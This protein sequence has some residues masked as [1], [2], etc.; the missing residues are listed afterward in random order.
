MIATR[1]NAIAQSIST[2][3]RN[4]LHAGCQNGP[5]TGKIVKIMIYTC[6]EM[7]RDCR[8]GRSEGWEYFLS[9]YVPVIRRLLVHYSP[10]QPGLL[11]RILPALRRPELSLF[12]ALEPMPERVFVA[13]LRQ[14][15]LEEIG[16]PAAATSLEL[17][18]VAAALAPLTLVEKQA[19]WM[20]TMLYSPEET[21][22][23]LRMAPATVA[24]I[25]TR[26][27]DLLRGTV[28]SWSSG[29][30]AA[31]GR[32]L[33]RSAAAARPPECIEAKVFL[34]VLDGR[35]TWRGREEM[36]RHAAGCLHCVDHFSRLAEALELVR[37]L[38]P[39]TVAETQP[40]RDFLGLEQTKTSGWKRWC[41]VS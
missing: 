27:G 20:E 18:E 31:N 7:V 11:E 33:G 10:E 19:A 6:Y 12:Q 37:G 30:L 29:I 40:F 15:V 34:D 39:L 25:R 13:E 2:L 28:D 4:P 3:P 14:R 26:A 38:K 24:K 16:A 41:G 1:K 5:K 17:E 35:M 8:A 36:E 9:N 32:Q 21:G 22:A 23:M